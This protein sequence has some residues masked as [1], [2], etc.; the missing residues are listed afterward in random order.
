MLHKPVLLNEVLHYLDPKTNENFIDA[1]VGQA[2]HTIAILKRTKPLGQVLGIDADLKQIEQSRIIAKDFQKR[3]FLV[4]DSYVNMREIALRMHFAPIDGIVLDLGMSSWHLENSTRGF[5]FLKNEMLDMRYDLKNTVTAEQIINS[6]PEQDLMVIFKDFGEEKFAGRIA[7]KV[8][9]ERQKKKIRT[10]FELIEVINKALS[11]Q[12]RRS[13]IHFATRV[14]QALRITVNKELENL[15]TFLPQA[16]EIL[17]SGGR[18]AV[19]SFHSL[20]D[21]IVKNFFN[22]TDGIKIL[23]KKPVTATQSEIKSNRRA[24]S[25]KLRAIMKK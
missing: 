23:T 10:T 5:S 7:K 11:P 3:I 6:Y 9:G 24:R 21:R 15:K 1:T 13:K 16:F 12:L 8:C 14:F 17:S 19:I 4:N 20:E 18:L 2:G 22:Q 25:A